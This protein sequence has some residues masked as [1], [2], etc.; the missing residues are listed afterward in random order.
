MLTLADI[1]RVTGGRIVGRSVRA[2]SPG[3]S[4]ADD[5]MSIKLDANAPDGFLVHLFNGGDPIAAKDFIRDRLGLPPFEPKAKTMNGSVERTIDRIRARTK[6]KPESKPK[7]K[8]IARYDYVTADGTL[9]YQ[10]DRLSP[11]RFRQRRP[12]PDGEWIYDRGD[13]PS[14]LYRLPELLKYPDGTV[15]FTEGEADAD[16]VAGLGLVATT[17]SGDAADKWTPELAAPLADRDVVIL[18][19]ADTKGEKRATVA[20][21]AL[22][23]LAKSVRVVLLSGLPPKGD[24]SDWLDA[25]HTQAELES[26]CVAAP[27]W[28]P[29]GAE[30]TSRP[31]LTYFGDCAAFVH[32]RWIMKGLIARGETSAWIAPPG[33]GKS[34]IMLDLAIHCAGRIDWRGHRA[35]DACGVLVL[36]LERADLCKRRLYAHSVRDKNLGNLPIAIHGGIIDLMNPA[37]VDTIVELVREAE[38][39]FECRVGLI[40]IDTDNKGIAAGGG[41]EDK[42][43]DRN[44]AAANMR[45]V[46]ELIDVHIAL[47]GHTGKDET[48]GARGSNAHLGDVDV[49]VQISGEAIKVAEVTKANDRP[50]GALTQFRLELIDL[51]NDEDEDEIRV[52]IVSTEAIAAPAPKAS[53]PKLTKNEKTMFGILHDAGRNGLSTEAWNNAGRAAGIGHGR[54]ADLHDAQSGLRR[55]KLV[56]EY[57]D[58]WHVNHRQDGVP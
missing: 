27:L 56:R 18:Q 13:T 33:A 21:Q 9:L 45:R 25:G 48:R 58:R 51:G 57:Q 15:F 31:R 46:Q 37:C 47:I 14:V 8:V 34:A 41:D 30:A 16:R 12:G 23:G 6:A 19:D 10:V 20:A 3:H 4:A 38:Q 22:H 55:K 1:A 35:K 44:R 29:D 11:K 2:P 40:V 36:A 43:R 42:A 39:H 32:K 53:E 49:M 50:D 17:V 5:G 24:V 28:R 7:A 26:I 52:A 54:R